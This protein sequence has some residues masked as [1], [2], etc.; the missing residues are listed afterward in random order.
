MCQ[1]LDPD[2]PS[3]STYKKP[4]CKID[5]YSAAAYRKEDAF[6]VYYFPEEE[7]RRGLLGSSITIVIDKSY[8]VADVIWHK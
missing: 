8:K 1:A 3:D 6:N 7:I 4:L 5:V 2:S